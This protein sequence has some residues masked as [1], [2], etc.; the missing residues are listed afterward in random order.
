MESSVNAISAGAW[1][2][3]AARAIGMIDDMISYA[4]ANAPLTRD[5]DPEEVGNAAAFLL[6]PLAAAIT[7]TVLF[8]DNGMHAM[9]LAIDSSA[10][11]SN[12]KY[13]SHFDR[14]EDF[15]CQGEGI[16]RKDAEGGRAVHE[17][18]IPRLAGDS[19]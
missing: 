2:S 7:G 9:G 19:F 15:F 4:K 3:R 16:E 13:A 12:E 5:L 8:V 11:Q 18:I 1:R 17:K 10:L 14:N 6:S